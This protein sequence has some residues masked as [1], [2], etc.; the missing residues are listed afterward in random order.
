MRHERNL[1]LFKGSH[2]QLCATCPGGGLFGPTSA[3]YWRAVNTQRTCLSPRLILTCKTMDIT[4]ILILTIMR[5]P[6]W[7]LHTGSNGHHPWSCLPMLKPHDHC[8]NVSQMF[9]F[10]DALEL[11]SEVWL[12]HFLSFIFNPKDYVHQ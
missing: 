8:Y 7:K 11:L 4:L 9:G 5:A 6:T 12:H 1:S 2:D 10:L 3:K